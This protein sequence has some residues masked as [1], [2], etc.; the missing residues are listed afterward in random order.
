MWPGRDAS[1]AG[2]TKKRRGG[3]RKRGYPEEISTRVFELTS[4][5][6]EGALARQRES[7]ASPRL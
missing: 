5:I 2:F 7:T 4:L 6:G 1:D 3:K